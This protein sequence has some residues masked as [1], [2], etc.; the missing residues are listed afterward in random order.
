MAL[1]VTAGGTLVLIAWWLDIAVVTQP[2]PMEANM[3]ANTA[4]GFVLGGISLALINGG[5]AQGGC[6][7]SS[8]CSWRASV[9]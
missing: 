9:S 1:L 8:R 2:L 4:A 6:R 7:S 3:K 5:S